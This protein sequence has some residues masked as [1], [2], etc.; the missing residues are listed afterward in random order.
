MTWASSLSPGVRMTAG[1]VVTTVGN[2]T[3]AEFWLEASGPL[4]TLLA[5]LLRRTVVSRNTRSATEGL[6]RY[7][8]E[9]RPRYRNQPHGGLASPRP[10]RPRRRDHFQGSPAS[11]SLRSDRGALTTARAFCGRLLSRQ[12]RRTQAMQAP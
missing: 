2:G 11:T 3:D 12:V 4:G 10:L 1:H 6:K 9:A 7:M 5:P 8:G